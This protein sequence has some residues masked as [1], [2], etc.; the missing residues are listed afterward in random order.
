MITDDM[1]KQLMSAGLTKQ[2]A[3]SATAETLI[4][5][6]MDEGSKVLVMEAR[7]QVSEMKKM[8]NSLRDEYRD[9]MNKMEEA[10]G[11]LAAVSETQKEYGEITDEKAKTVVALYAAL[12]SINNRIGANPTESVRNA[13][14]VLYAFLGGQ[15]RRDIAYFSPE[16]S[17]YPGSLNTDRK[18]RT[19]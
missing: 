16:D 18:V 12:L 9:L 6:F 8:L 10:A 11:I 2:Q 19:I 3:T 1:V 5:L 4:D 15:A 13:G 7:Q 17:I 14:Y